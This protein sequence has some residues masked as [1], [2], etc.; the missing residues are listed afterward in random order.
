MGK[1]LIIFSFTALTFQKHELEYGITRA[2]AGHP[3]NKQLLMIFHD[4]N[5][6]L[7]DCVEK[8][9][10]E[11]IKIEQN[12]NWF[13]RVD[14]SNKFVY[15]LDEDAQTIW[16]VDWNLNQQPSLHWDNPTHPN[17]TVQVYALYAAKN[18]S[19][20]CLQMVNEK[21]VWVLENDSGRITHRLP[22]MWGGNICFMQNDRFFYNTNRFGDQ[23]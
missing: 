16:K 3:D 12:I 5:I 10:T 18:D 20:L 15:A 13:G 19:I 4:K 6:S 23:V 8:E 7:F 21:E 1:D 2:L 17:E 14:N 22:F 11:T 9:V